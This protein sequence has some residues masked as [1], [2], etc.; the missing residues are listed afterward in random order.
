MQLVDDCDGVCILSLTP[1]QSA[2]ASMQLQGSYRAT[3]R[4]HDCLHRSW[5]AIGWE[6][7]K[8]AGG[9]GDDV[10]VFGILAWISTYCP[11]LVQNLQ[12][13]SF[14]SFFYMNRS[15]LP[16]QY[17]SRKRQRKRALSIIPKSTKLEVI[18]IVWAPNEP[19]KTVLQQNLQICLRKIVSQ[20]NNF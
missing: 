8:G 4:L 16:H 10:G 1:N 5:A 14:T 15:A 2:D 18:V 6:S 17:P 7:G 3:H 12:N 19:A 11:G 13:S 20:E 9:G